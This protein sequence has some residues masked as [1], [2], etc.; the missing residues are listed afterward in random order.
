MQLV[1]TLS[2]PIKI[3]QMPKTTINI[4]PLSFVQSPHEKHSNLY[5]YTL[6]CFVLSTYSDITKQE[7][8]KDLILIRLKTLKLHVATPIRG[9]LNHSVF[10]KQFYYSFN[11]YQTIYT[12]IA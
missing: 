1:I 8:V 7:G 3:C 2:K 10:L 4:K 6:S 5:S 9:M 11:T 12:I